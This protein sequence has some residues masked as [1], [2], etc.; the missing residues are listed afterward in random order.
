MRSLQDCQVRDILLLQ[1]EEGPASGDKLAME[2]HFE[3]L[4]SRTIP[5]TK[6]LWVSLKAMPEIRA[7]V[8]VVYLGSDP[9]NHEWPSKKNEMVTIECLIQPNLI[10]ATRDF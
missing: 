1:L 2:F 6:C 4:L 8:Q 7:W 10:W 3:G 5:G 9:T